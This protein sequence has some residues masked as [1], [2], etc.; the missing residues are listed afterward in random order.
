M[1]NLLLA[2]LPVDELNRVL[3]VLE[4]VPI[5]RKTVIYKVGDPIKFVYFPSGGL[6][7]EVASLQ[8]GQGLEVNSVGREGAFGISALFGLQ[9]SLHE[10]TVQITGAAWRVEVDTLRR[11]GESCP[12]LKDRMMRYFNATFFE[13]A[14]TAACNGRHSV[15]QRCANKL[16]DAYTRSGGMYLPLTHENLA[17][18]L[19]CRPAARHR[20][21]LQ[22]ISCKSLQTLVSSYRGYSQ[23]GSGGDRPL[24][25]AV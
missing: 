25:R 24:L 9:H 15:L 5:V 16:L 22:F 10:I 8:D 1:L 23:F 19:G 7:G 13:V 11:V 17:A 2:S 21:R 4:T 3:M 12:V 20:V 6:I 18:A 14:Q